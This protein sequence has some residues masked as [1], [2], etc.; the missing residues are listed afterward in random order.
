M[1]ST[2]Y[3]RGKKWRDYYQS[4]TFLVVKLIY[5]DLFSHAIFQYHIDKFHQA[6]LLATEG[7]LGLK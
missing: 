5:F 3:V 2:Q 4:I 1:E 6:V 7:I